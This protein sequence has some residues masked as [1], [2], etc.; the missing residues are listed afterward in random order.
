MGLW[1]WTGALLTWLALQLWILPKLGVATC[2]VPRQPS[3]P[4]LPE[5]EPPAADIPLA[6]FA[7]TP[8]PRKPWPRPLRA[9]Y[10]QANSPRR[11]L[12]R[13]RET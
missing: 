1:G 13:L 6:E 2:A 5:R 9:E 3:Y 7:A 12:R 10:R 4:P 11:T 8:P